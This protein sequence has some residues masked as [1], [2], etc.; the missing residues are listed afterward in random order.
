MLGLCQNPNPLKYTNPEVELH[1]PHPPPKIGPGP[2]SLVL[3]LKTHGER[4]AYVTN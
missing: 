4:V 1:I 3:L 2:R